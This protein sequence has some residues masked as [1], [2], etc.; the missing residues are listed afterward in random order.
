V[1]E[2]WW[3]LAVGAVAI[4]LAV[5]SFWNVAIARLPEDR[6][7]W[8]PSACEACGA[9]I[10]ARDNLPVVSWV[11]LR[12]RCRACRAPIPIVHP[13][14][15]LLGGMLAWLV[16]C[17]FVPPSD[18][19]AATLATAACAFALV[20][21]LVIAT[22]I[23]VGHRIIPD[24][25]SSYAVPFAIAAIALLGFLGASDPVVVSWKAS[26]LGAAAA[27]GFLGS[28]AWFANWMTGQEALGWGDVKLAM[29]LGAAFGPL[30]GAFTILLLASLLGASTGL[31]ATLVAR[32]RVHLPFGPALALAALMYLL[33]GAEIGAAIL[34]GM[35][36]GLLIL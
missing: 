1:T 33:W 27:G 35:T 30:P 3:T 9:P 10:R 18:L 28:V 29:L 6:S 16:F 36:R 21:L 14:G 25:T 4:G 32:R 26:I 31:V 12:G 24:G 15:E 17:R 13:L 20:T 5:G 23:D 11:L 7:L 8:K 2:T 34:P 19:S 22:Y